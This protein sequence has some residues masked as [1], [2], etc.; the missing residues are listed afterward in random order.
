MGKTITSLDRIDQA[1]ENLKKRFPQIKLKRV[2]VNLALDLPITNEN[3]RAQ[4]EEEF[5]D[6]DE[7]DL[8][9]EMISNALVMSQSPKK[10][11]PYNTF[12]K[13]YVKTLDEKH[14]R[15]FSED[16]LPE[17]KYDPKLLIL[18]AVAFTGQRY[19]EG[20]KYEDV[21]I[22]DEKIR[23]QVLNLKKTNK[24]KAK[25]SIFGKINNFYFNK[26]KVD[27]V[28]NVQ[29]RKDH[30]DYQ[31]DNNMYASMDVGKQRSSL[32]DGVLMLDHPKNYKFRLLAV[33]SSGIVIRKRVSNEVLRSLLNWFENLS[34][35]YYEDIDGLKELIENKMMQINNEIS[36]SGKGSV[37]CAIVGKDKTL[38]Y[39]VG[40][41]RGYKV[42]DNKLTGIT[43]D[44][45]FIG[46][47]CSNG[48]IDRFESRFYRGQNLY[49]NELGTAGNEKEL[50]N[51]SEVIPND[52]DKLLL[53][54]KG[55][56]KSLEDRDI[57]AIL[58]RE[59]D[60]EVVKR[61]VEKAVNEESHI[62]EPRFGY[63]TFIK[64]GEENTTALMY[65]K[66]K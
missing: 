8:I 54:T 55:V 14:L 40:D 30:I 49:I 25:S 48:V 7:N 66:R 47:L 41:T 12:C 53:V 28:R 33:A 13:N 36:E 9:R 22:R 46:R 50:R 6:I 15:D 38:I 44:D 2:L 60:P 57:E 65:V 29:V 23:E 34:V 61:I 11:I 24:E 39:S 64:P 20:I 32:N 3:I 62:S 59:E 4:V 10:D 35:D 21:V 42:V 16:I 45:T 18:A 43:E 56:T 37:T 51:R 63:E 17:T 58:S 26:T 27:V 5:K 19:Y 1:V 52:Y 31:V